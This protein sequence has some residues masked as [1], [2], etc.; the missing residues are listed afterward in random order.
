MYS[1]FFGPMIIRHTADIYSKR[2]TRGEYYTKAVF[3][4]I[5]KAIFRY[6]F[7]RQNHI[8]IVSKNIVVIHIWRK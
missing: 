4:R 2:Y 1:E 3:Q 6:K 8:Q 5:T 7:A